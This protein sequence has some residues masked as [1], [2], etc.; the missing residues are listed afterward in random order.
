MKKK[1]G[2]AAAFLLVVGIISGTLFNQGA[3]AIVPGVNTLVSVNNTGDGQGGNGAS[4]DDNGYYE[5][6]QAVSADGRYVVF[7]SNASNLVSNDTNGRNDVFV[8][9]LANGTTTRVDVSS[10][11]VQANDG[12]NNS[13]FQ[14]VAISST[15][16]YVV[17]TSMATNLMDGQ[18]T[19]HKQVYMHD[20]ST[21]VTSVVSKKSDGT[22]SNKDVVGVYG[23]SSDGR[24]V[25]W[26]GNLLTS[27][28]TAETNTSSYYI[29][30]TDLQNQ[31]TTI[32]NHTPPTG[33]YF[34]YGATMSCD[35]AF[36]AFSTKLQ[37]VSSDTDSRMDVYL[38]DLRNGT[39][40]TGIT[41]L[42]STDS[43]DVFPSFSCN[44][45][46]LTFQ[47][48]GV[49]LVTSPSN[50]TGLHQIVYDR[51]NASFA[52]ADTSTTG[53][54]ANATTGNFYG[55]AVDDY[56]DAIFNSHASNLID[57]HVI[58][59]PQVYLKHG[60]SGVTELLSTIPGG[61]GWSGSNGIADGRVT[62]SADGSVATY[63]VS[64][65]TDVLGSHTNGFGDVIASSTGL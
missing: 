31:T 16:R 18:T 41:T 51:L 54:M 55:G 46:F 35:G 25:A 11:G 40:T 19:S 14:S 10:S 58:S 38:V 26:E 63:S 24:L 21:G 22:L 32:L 48:N 20:M 53:A 7:T 39:T 36:I 60:G 6:N 62:I 8:R 23:V 1:I 64:A 42:S 56:G 5:L 17:F 59:H 61:S 65:A 45:N 9:D 49:G 27:L 15:G 57:G 33:Q 37:L 44:G 43:D 13:D 30:L 28:T 4:P 50:P 3:N 29:Y 2:R 34:L 52:M 12:I 47:S